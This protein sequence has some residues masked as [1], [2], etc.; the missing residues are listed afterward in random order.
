V[1]ELLRSALEV[2]AAEVGGD[3]ELVKH[4]PGSWEADHVRHLGAVI[5]FQPNDRSAM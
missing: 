2:V 4:R 5:T 1:P 3:E